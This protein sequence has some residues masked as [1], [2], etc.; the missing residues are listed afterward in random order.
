MNFCQGIR[1]E[2]RA[3]LKRAYSSPEDDLRAAQAPGSTQYFINRVQHLV[4]VRFGTKVTVD[5]IARYSTRLRSDP[6]FEPTMSEIVDLHDAEE[7]DLQAG[8]FFRLADQIDPFSMHAKRAF[9]VRT[10]VQKHAAR[11]HKILRTQRNIEVF[12]SVEEAERWI[13]GG[14]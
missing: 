7:L 14:S 4:L 13:N 9:V 11:M 2:M 1:Q 6:C 3:L 10:S 8:D 5:D 12:R